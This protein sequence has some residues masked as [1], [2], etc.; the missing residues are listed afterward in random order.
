MFLTSH[1]P[2]ESSFL[3]RLSSVAAYLGTSENALLGVMWVESRIKP[4]ARN[5][6]TGAVGLIQFMPSTCTSLGTAASAIQAMS[7]TNQLAYVQKYLSPYRGRISSFFDLYVAVF[8]PYAL[9]KP[10]SF[11]LPEI[12]AKYNS[13]FDLN[14]NGIITIGEIK[15]KLKAILPSYAK[16][17]I[18]NYAVPVLLL[19]GAGLVFLFI[20]KKNK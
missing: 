14:Q 15:Q 20:R 16:S 6:K 1:L 2:D 4:A 18:Q 13:A 9:G 3:A 5:E 17:L 8:Y 12:V 10:D 19:V 7:A 11:Q